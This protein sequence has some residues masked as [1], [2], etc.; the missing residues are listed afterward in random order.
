[1]KGVLIV[2][3]GVLLLTGSAKAKPS[4]VGTIR[5]AKADIATLY[6]SQGITARA[7][8]PLRSCRKPRYRKWL[9]QMTV[10]WRSAAGQSGVFW[11]G[12]RVGRNSYVA[13]L[14]IRGDAPDWCRVQFP[15]A[16]CRTSHP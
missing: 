5:L 16:M 9:C 10:Y 11:A 1:M 14:R 6:A 13:L 15:A 7:V 8:V 12:L 3:V 4:E 2:V